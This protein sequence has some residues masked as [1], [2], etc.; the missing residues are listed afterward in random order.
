MNA[1]CSTGNFCPLVPIEVIHVK[2]SVLGCSNLTS[3]FFH[4][5]LKTCTFLVTYPY[6]KVYIHIPNKQLSS[7]QVFWLSPSKWRTENPITV[8]CCSATSVTGLTENSELTSNLLNSRVWKVEKWK[9]NITFS[10]PE[11]WH[12]CILGLFCSQPICWD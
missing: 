5:S 8:F 4:L 11:S 7:G 1:S 10:V 9:K 3:L 12:K 6:N 2:L